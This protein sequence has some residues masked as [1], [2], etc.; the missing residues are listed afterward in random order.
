MLRGRYI[1][2]KLKKAWF[3]IIFFQSK[4]NVS[5][6]VV[7]VFSLLFN[8]FVFLFLSTYT[9]LGF[10][11]TASNFFL[12]LRT[13]TPTA[14]AADLATRDTSTTFAADPG[15]QQK[16]RAGTDDPKFLLIPRCI[17]ESEQGGLRKNG[18]ALIGRYRSMLDKRSPIRILTARR[19][20]WIWWFSEPCTDPATTSIGVFS[21][22]I[23]NYRTKNCH[24]MMIFY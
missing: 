5:S 17:H 3:S 2:T 20:A 23:F 13:R 10:Y 4:Q 6:K 18:L 14:A 7:S 11:G 24:K 16:T 12:S 22:L 15:K 1:Y 8:F 21:L 19:A 9:L